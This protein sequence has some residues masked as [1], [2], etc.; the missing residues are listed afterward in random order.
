MAAAAAFVL[1]VAVTALSLPLAAAMTIAIGA[2]FGFWTGLVIVSFAASIGATLAFLAARHIAR[3]WVAARFGD[4][5]ADGIDG[6]VARRLGPTDRGAF[7]DI[8][9]D[10]VFYAAV[11]LGFALADPAAN[12]LPAAVLIFAFV[13]TM[14]SF[15]AFSVIAG[16]R[17]MRAADYPA[18]GIYYLGGLTEGAETIAVFVAMCLWPAAFPWLAYGFAAACALTVA[19]R[20]HMGWTAFAP[21]R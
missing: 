15:L 1:Y 10:F 12:A 14:S 9:L 8:A 19:A 11:P 17:R 20:W 21:R 3:D 16:Q 13:G 5:L 2:L 6:A 7:L 4:R 18:K